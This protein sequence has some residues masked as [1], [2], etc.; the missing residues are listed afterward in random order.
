MQ[1]DFAATRSNTGDPVPAGVGGHWP[2]PVFVVVSILF[3]GEWLLPGRVLLPTD[4]ESVWPW[5]RVA[6]GAPLPSNSL[7]SDSLTL[8]YT[9]RV[10]NHIMLRQGRVPFWNPHILCGTPH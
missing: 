6:E 2:I 9:S 4:S 1:Q 10:Y 3:C 8:T 7:L 5:T